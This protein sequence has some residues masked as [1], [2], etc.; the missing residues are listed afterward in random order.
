MKSFED[1]KNSPFRIAL[2]LLDGF[3]SMAMQ[4]FIDPFRCANYLLGEKLYDW[5]FLSHGVDK[6]TASNGLVVS[7]LKM[8]GAVPDTFDCIAV[9]ASW[10]VERFKDPIIQAWLQRHAQNNAAICGLD[11]GAF[12]LGYAGLLKGKK[13]A[14]HY[15][16]IAAFR[17]TFPDTHMGEDLFVMDGNLLTCCGGTASVDL[18]LEMIRVQQGIEAANAA[19]RY[20]FHERFRAGDEGQ[21][22]ATREP[23]GYSAPEKLREAIVLMERSLEHLLSI[24]EIA[25]HVALSQ[26]QLE[27]LFKTHTSVS[28]VRY[29]LDVRLDRARGLV[30]QTQLPIVDI[31]VACGFSTSAQFSRSY[32]SRF[33]I[34]PSADRIEGRVPFQFRSFPSHAGV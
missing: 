5:Q 32:R 3:N 14:V 17:E 26:R 19:S 31:A 7:D 12:V 25:E 6:I 18:A 29:Y 24:G 34:S 28:P 10:G 27:R 11:T 22:P 9:N 8:I 23:I 2:L 30:T 13:A 15:E 20:I 16:H 21:L 4:A 33:H 1:S